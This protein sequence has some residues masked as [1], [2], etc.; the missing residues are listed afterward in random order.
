MNAALWPTP[1]PAAPPRAPRGTYPALADLFPG[2]TFTQTQADIIARLRNGQDIRSYDHGIEWRA[3]I[4]LHQRGIIDVDATT[5]RLYLLTADIRDR[6]LGELSRLIA[7]LDAEAESLLSARAAATDQLR[8][9][10]DRL[11]AEESALRTLDAAWRTCPPQ[12]RA[13][14][15]QLCADL[16]VA[17]REEADAR[18]TYRLL[19][20]ADYGRARR[21]EVVGATLRGL[22][23]EQAR[24]QAHTGPGPGQGGDR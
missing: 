1:R 13:T 3:L 5:N 12:L 8:R 11:R 14:R 22:R 16:A 23:Q 10:S 21:A 19:L 18:E 9:A 24:L 7:E 17:R 20:N 15:R 6:R 2:Q 4:R